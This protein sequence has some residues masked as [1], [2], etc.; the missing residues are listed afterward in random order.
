[1]T[2]GTVVMSQGSVYELRG[3]RVFCAVDDAG[4]PKTYGA[5]RVCELE[6]C[7]TL[8]SRYNPSALCCLH[9][10]GWSEARLERCVERKQLVRLCRLESCARE[11]VTTN[12]AR[13]YCSDY[14]RMRANAARQDERRREGIAV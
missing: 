9:G 12:P 10:R 5:G 8:L 13:K 3:S 1:M 11:F 7:D 6:G 2:G 4:R 14:C